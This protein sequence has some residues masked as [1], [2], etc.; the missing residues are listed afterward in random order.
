VQAPQRRDTPRSTGGGIDR[1]WLIGGAL[2]AAAAV[3]IVLAL[4]LTGGGGGSSSTSAKTIDWSTIPNLQGGPPPWGPDWQA[5]PD[6]LQPLGLS[7]LSAEGTVLHVHQH[8]DLYVNGQHV[9]VPA[10]IGIYG[11]SFITELHTH[12][13]SGIIHVE[14]PVKTNFVLGQFFGEWGIRLTK[15]CVGNYCGK[16]S[17]WVDGVKQSGNPAQLVLKSHEVIVIALGKPPATI[18][19]TYTWNGL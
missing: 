1:R 8:L 2:V 11:Q 6:R 7:Q 10:D 9:P 15:S 4:V 13:S 3:A 18:R 17:W 19:K 12:D 14:S 16:L 5:L